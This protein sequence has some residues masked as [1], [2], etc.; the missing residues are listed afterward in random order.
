MALLEDSCTI[1]RN[2]VKKERK[3]KKKELR[4]SVE[5]AQGKG[6]NEIVPDVLKWLHGVLKKYKPRKKGSNADGC[7]TTRRYC[8]CKNYRKNVA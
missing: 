3:E 6:D 2:E 4:L 8:R 5:G 1:G 7:S